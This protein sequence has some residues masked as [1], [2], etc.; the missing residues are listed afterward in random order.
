[1]RERCVDP[2][3]TGTPVEARGT[4]SLCHSGRDKPTPSVV[5]VAV[6]F[7]GAGDSAKLIHPL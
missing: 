4:C 6:R 2:G 5:L 3:T 1:V 7:S